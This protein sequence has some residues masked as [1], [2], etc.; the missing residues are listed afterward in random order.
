MNKAKIHI[1]EMHNIVD[2]CSRADQSTGGQELPD[3]RNYKQGLCQM[4]DEFIIRASPLCILGIK[5]NSNNGQCA[6]LSTKR[7]LIFNELN[8]EL[9]KKV[10]S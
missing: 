3:Y 4:L 1:S 7:S 6:G 9:Y 2:V 8:K 10:L 5:E